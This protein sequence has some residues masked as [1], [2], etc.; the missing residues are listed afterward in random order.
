MAYDVQVKAGASA[1]IFAGQ[2]GY[3]GQQG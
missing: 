1:G 2:W 3:T